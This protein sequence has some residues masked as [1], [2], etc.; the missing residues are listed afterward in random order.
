[1]SVDCALTTLIESQRQALSK[2]VARQILLIF[3][4][5][6]LDSGVTSEAGKLSRK[7]IRFVCVTAP[8]P[9]LACKSYVNES[10]CVLYVLCAS[11]VS[12]GEYVVSNGD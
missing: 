1:M 8:V 9:I 12:N 2:T 7:N 10:L 6:A 4:I 5:V 11:V 3:M